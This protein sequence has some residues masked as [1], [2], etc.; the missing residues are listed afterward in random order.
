MTTTMLEE[1]T[2]RED[3]PPRRT[4]TDRVPSKWDRVI[5][6]LQ[7]RPG[8]W[9]TFQGK[10]RQITNYLRGR[11]P[12][13]VAEGHHGYKDDEGTRRIELWLCWPKP[14]TAPGPPPVAR[15]TTRGAA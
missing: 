15:T 11:Y 6:A 9:M 12:G 8:V 13:L 3:Q 5:E 10:S 4:R 1:G 7:Q 14:G 2:W